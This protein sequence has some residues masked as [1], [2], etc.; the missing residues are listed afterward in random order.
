VRIEASLERRDGLDG[1][2]GA[3]PLPFAARHHRDA[4]QLAQAREHLSMPEGG[5]APEIA[6]LSDQP[7]GVAGVLEPQQV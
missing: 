3:Q 4:D 6:T 2:V 7:V 5:V 1:V